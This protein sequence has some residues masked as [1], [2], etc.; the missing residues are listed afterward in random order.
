MKEHAT[1]TDRKNLDPVTVVV[2]NHVKRDKVAEFKKWSSGITR[3][4]NSFPGHQGTS[5]VKNPESDSEQSIVYTTIIRFDNHLN[6][7]LWEESE[8]RNLW[9][10]R[11]KPLVEKESA[12]RKEDGIEFW[13]DLPET[14]ITTMATI[15]PKP[16]RHRMALVT[17]LA[18][19]PL[20]LLVPSLVSQITP[21][22]VPWYLETLI[23]CI[24][25]VFLMT[26]IV[27]PAM[28]RIFSFWLFQR[29]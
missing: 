20:I 11:L 5:I 4:A 1:R 25:T 15:A 24:C 23:S 14:P 7:A 26:W 27:M 2:S 21:P 10:E 13:F 17:L 28:T 8:E 6:L 9:I 16:P 18:I 22:A 12:Y 3:A 19:Y 29:K